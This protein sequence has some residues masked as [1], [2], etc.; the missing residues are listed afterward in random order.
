V[1]AD[2]FRGQDQQAA[3]KGAAAGDIP[4]TASAKEPCVRWNTEDPDQAGH[5][6]QCLYTN[7]KG[8]CKYAHKCTG[9]GGNLPKWKCGCA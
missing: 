1:S 4:G 6:K 3:L 7:K 5:S 2:I 8:H 9:C